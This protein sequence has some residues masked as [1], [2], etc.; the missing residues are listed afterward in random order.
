PAGQTSVSVPL[1]VIDN[2]LLD[3]DEAVTLGA[4]TSGYL[5][6]TSA[7]TV[8]DDETAA[9]TVSLPANVSE[10]GGQVTGTMTASAAPAKDITV[11]L[12]SNLTSRLTVPATVTIKAGQ[13][14]A[15]FVATIINN[16]VID[17]T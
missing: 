2:G 6:G 3:G 1:T 15:S 5:P 16:G 13:T 11:Q 17:G 7:V 8:H 10:S 4:S 9:L 14:S 12:S